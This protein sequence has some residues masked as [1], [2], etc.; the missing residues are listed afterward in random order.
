MGVLIGA[1]GGVLFGAVLA[2]RCVPGSLGACQAT[3][4]TV[5]SV[6]AGTLAGAFAGG[7][8]GALFQ[9]WEVVR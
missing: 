2:P 9:K 8:V 5:A 4:L 6:I 3:G 7:V 1:A